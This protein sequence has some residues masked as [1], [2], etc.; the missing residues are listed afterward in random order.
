LGTPASLGK[1]YL[2]A[3]GSDRLGSLILRFSKAL[4]ASV[5]DNGNPST[6]FGVGIELEDSLQ[7]ITDP[8]GPYQPVRYRELSARRNIL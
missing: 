7:D 5:M 3:A 8:V 4:A 1:T 6:W 2:Q